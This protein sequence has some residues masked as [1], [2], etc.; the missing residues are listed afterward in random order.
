MHTSI[1]YSNSF[2]NENENESHGNGNGNGKGSHYY[3][4]VNHSNYLL[5]GSATLSNIQHII[6]LRC[7]N[8]VHIITLHESPLP[9]DILVGLNE[10]GIQTYHYNIVD[11]HPPTI[12]QMNAL[13]K[14]ISQAI[15]KNEGILIHCQGGVGR[16]NCVLAAYLI[17]YKNMSPNE[18]MEVLERTQRKIILSPSQEKMLSHWW[19][20]VTNNNCDDNNNNNNDNNMDY[21]CDAG[22]NDHMNNSNDNGAMNRSLAQHQDTSLKSVID[23]TSASDRTPGDRVPTATYSYNRLY[24]ALRIPPLVVLCG[25][26]ASGKSTFSK[27]LV[28]NYPN[29]FIRVNRDEMR[30]KGEVDAVIQKAF[31]GDKAKNNNNNKCSTLVVDGCNLTRNKRN[32][33]I[34]AAHKTRSW[35]I[36]FDIPI[37]ECMYRIV[38][39]SGHPTIPSGPAGLTILRSMEKQLQPPTEEEGF[40][41]IIHV[42]SVRDI[43]LLC[44]EWNINL[45]ID[46]EVLHSNTENDPHTSNDHV[47][48]S[49]LDDNNHENEM[50][51]RNEDNSDDN[52]NDKIIKF[53]RIPH[54]IDIGGA[55]RDDKIAPHSAITSLINS[56]QIVTIEEKLDG[57]N[58]GIFINNNNEI[59]VQNRSHTISASYHPQFK[60]LTKWIHQHT[61]DLFEILEPNRHVLYGEWLYATHSVCYTHLPDW[62]IAY[63]LYDKINKTFCSRKVLENKLSKTTIFHVPMIYEGPID[64]IDQII[65]MTTRI[66][67]FS[68]HVL[69]GIIIRF[70]DNY[71]DEEN[72]HLISRMKLVRKDFICGNERWNRTAKLKTNELRYEK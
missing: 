40:E 67:H 60:L 15:S 46:N 44:H 26:A 34:E 52:N 13:M 37:E 24:K 47:N 50:G 7:N 9:T 66:S 3:S 64:S 65:Q 69:E 23:T 56:R 32:E 62:F 43:E 14:I 45:S 33:W 12:E 53:P 38:R 57:A 18:A 1:R 11:R 72:G 49:L 58:M 63:D 6:S 42:T 51:I 21:N 41:R 2:F 30:G 68:T 19:G 17:K 61:E 54:V 16:T 31:R 20:Y 8:I 39:R 36:F 5:C 55:T 22:M 4:D 70:D 10:Y 28:K 48:T 29:Y 59:I 25:Y 27:A 71:C 35:C